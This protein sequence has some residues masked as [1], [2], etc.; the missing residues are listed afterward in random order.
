M[1][2]ISS[3]KKTRVGRPTVDTEAV[4]VR[5]PRQQLDAIDAWAADEPD[6][7]GRPEAVRRLVDLGLKAAKRK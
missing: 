4:N 2:T 1:A 6:D 5:M 7:P 3:A